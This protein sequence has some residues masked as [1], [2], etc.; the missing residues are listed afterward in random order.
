MSV[1]LIPLFFPWVTMIVVAAHL[2]EARLVAGHQANSAHPFGALPEV[3]VGN[4][5]TRRSAV[6][7]L[8]RL[9]AKIKSDPRLSTRYI[10]QRQVG[11]IAAVGEGGD[12][13][14]RGFDAVEEGIDRDPFPD[15]I[16]L[17]PVGDAVNVFG[18]RL[19]VQG[20]KLFPGPAL[21]RI[22]L[23]LDSEVPLIEWRVRRRA[24]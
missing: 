9:S 3:E 7:G 16:E 8:Q 13:L 6:L 19:M 21:G 20:L 17:G 24:G 15:R 22:D 5:Q 23:T 1:A 18:D 14:R 2:P 11:R 10:L 12:V 4:Q